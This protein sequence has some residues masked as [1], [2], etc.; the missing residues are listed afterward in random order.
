MA[1]KRGRTLLIALIVTFGLFAACP[2]TWMIVG[3]AVSNYA[4][5]KP[6]PADQSASIAED[7]E[8]IFEGQAENV[9]VQQAEKD[10]GEQGKR[11]GYESSW[12]LGNTPAKV[13]TWLPGADIES[14]AQNHPAFPSSQGITPEEYVAIA[15]AWTEGCGE[16][17]LTGIW[18]ARDFGMNGQMVEK[19]GRYRYQDC[20]VVGQYMG[21]F[22]PPT[23]G[24]NAEAQGWVVF[25]DRLNDRSVY[26]GPVDDVIRYET[27]KRRF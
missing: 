24:V 25:H 15:K 23:R 6:E 12:T 14:I 2:F 8:V 11:W 7:I 5:P 13:V 9:D 18:R 1:S 3:S 26:V 4:M 20:Y 21:D 27:R 22:A 10:A 19:F 17:E 16:K